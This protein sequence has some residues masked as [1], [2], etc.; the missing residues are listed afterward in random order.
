MTTFFYTV[1]VFIISGLV[2][3]S[4]P[5]TAQSGDKTAE[6]PP[7]IAQ[8]LVREG[9]FAVKLSQALKLGPVTNF[10]QKR[11]EGRTRVR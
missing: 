5:A 8:P 10:L 7:I 6:N 3:M 4:G 1:I 11:P 9:D 2:M